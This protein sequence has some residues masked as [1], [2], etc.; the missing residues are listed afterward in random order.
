VKGELACSPRI[1]AALFE[2]LAALSSKSAAARWDSVLTP[3]EREIAGL[4]VRGLPNKVIARDLFL[5]PA[6]V[7]NHVHNIL[8]KLNLQPRGEIA[9]L[10]LDADIA[11]SDVQTSN[12]R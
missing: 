3:R 10:R 7:K 11:R 9:T 1:A 12:S 6:T 5:E 8:Q 4:L 2:R